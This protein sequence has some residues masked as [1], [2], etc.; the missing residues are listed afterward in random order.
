MTFTS[1]AK[2]LTKP[3]IVR[4]KEDKF[5]LFVDRPFSLLIKTKYRK[6]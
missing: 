3:I 5:T 6:N 2:T 4:G 1:D